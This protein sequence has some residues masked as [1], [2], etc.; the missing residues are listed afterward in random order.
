MIILTGNT[1]DELDEKLHD[2][3]FLVC[4]LGSLAYVQVECEFNR[5][6]VDILMEELEDFEV[7]VV[8][9]LDRLGPKET[10][11]FGIL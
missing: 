2:T 10:S 9:V 6:N 4:S 1:H 5:R 8:A 11:L 3:D 7:T